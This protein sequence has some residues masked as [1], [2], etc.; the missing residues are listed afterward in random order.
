MNVATLKLGSYQTILGMGRGIWID[1]GI[2]S[3]GKLDRKPQKENP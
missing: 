1:V 3:L 2:G